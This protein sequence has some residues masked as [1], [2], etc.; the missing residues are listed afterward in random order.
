MIT[1]SHSKTEYFRVLLPSLSGVCVIRC[2]S[3]YYL[4]QIGSSSAW[5]YSGVMCVSPL[6][7]SGSLRGLSMLLL[8]SLS[9]RE[10]IDLYSIVYSQTAP[11]IERP[12][13]DHSFF[14]DIS[15]WT[16]PVLDVSNS[17]HPN[18]CREIEFDIDRRSSKYQ[19]VSLN[20]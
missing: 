11:S 13:I 15:V 1:Q 2:L 14:S 4:G 3:F 8:L 20:T 10:H 12:N 19:R 9:R 5:D 18:Y 7:V 16:A 17:R 6:F